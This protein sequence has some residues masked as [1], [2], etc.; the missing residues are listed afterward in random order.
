MN[1]APYG[2]GRCATF[3]LSPVLILLSHFPQFPVVICSKDNSEHAFPYWKLNSL[4]MSMTCLEKF[5]FNM[6]KMLLFK[7]HALILCLVIY[8][9][10]HTKLLLTASYPQDY[11]STSYCE[12]CE[13]LKTE[14]SSCI[15]L[16]AFYSITLCNFPNLCKSYISSW[17]WV[18]QEEENFSDA[19][20]ALWDPPVEKFL[21]GVC[22]KKCHAT[23][24][25]GFKS[26]N[27]SVERKIKISAWRN[28]VFPSME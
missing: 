7:D 3:L 13:G 8:K 28:K 20:K 14:F 12:G 10:N 15:W 26:Q 27:D 9:G 21:L 16:L 19:W 23:S 1:S 24:S 22:T 2:N 6:Y 4:S 25:K 18:Q 17:K 11:I 5:I